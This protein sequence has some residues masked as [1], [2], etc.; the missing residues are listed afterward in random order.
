[1]S[2]QFCWLA[3]FV[4]LLSSV[5][6]TGCGR[7]GAPASLLPFEQQNHG[8]HSRGRPESLAKLDPSLPVVS[9][10]G[11]QTRVQHSERP[12]L[13]QFGVNYGCYRCDQ[14]R[15]EIS[16]LAREF[17][18]RADVVRVDFNANRQLAAQFGTT[19]CPSYVLFDRGHVVAKRSF[20][21]S[22]DLLATDLGSTLTD[23][24]G[25]ERRSSRMV[26]SFSVAD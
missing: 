16:R 3:R 15:P 25:G 26:V 2:V 14:M 6:L 4:G 11:L 17:E 22:A 1:M 7:S 8:H 5:W 12:L 13:V 23:D 9:G 10:S 19:I 24:K 18:G 20:P 21:T